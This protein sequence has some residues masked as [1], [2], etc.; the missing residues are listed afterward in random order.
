[1][2]KYSIPRLVGVIFI[3]SF[4]LKGCASLVDESSSQLQQSGAMVRSDSSLEAMRR[5]ELAAE[6]PLKSLYFDY[7]R[8]DLRVDA[9]ETLKANV[10]WLK[11]HS[12]VRV[13]IEGHAD[14]RGTNEYNLALAFKR[15][16]S[17]KDYLLSLGV[18]DERI[19]TISYGEE[20]PAC[21]DQNEKCWQKNRR[22]RFVV[23]ATGPAS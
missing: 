10:D 6:G 17:S 15:A 14:E 8:Y 7:D 16:Q 23:V 21:R 20:V 2:G 18:P 22:A 4:L 19:S 5:G 1:M 9:R 3:A 11:S 13:E 12:A